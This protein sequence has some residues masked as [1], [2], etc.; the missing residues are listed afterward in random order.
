LKLKSQLQNELA[1][2][3]SREIMALMEDEKARELAQAMPERILNAEAQSRSAY[4]EREAWARAA[5]D[6]ALATMDIRYEAAMEA[7]SQGQLERLCNLEEECRCQRT[8][9]ADAEAQALQ[10]I[11]SATQDQA[12]GLIQA[13]A[14]ARAARRVGW[15]R[16]ARGWLKDATSARKAADDRC[17]AAMAAAYDAYRQAMAEAMI[18][19]AGQISDAGLIA[20]AR[21]TEIANGLSLN[22]LYIAQEL[23]DRL[24][25]CAQSGTEGIERLLAGLDNWRV[26]AA[27]DAT[28]SEL[29]RADEEAHRALILSYFQEMVSLRADGDERTHQAFAAYRREQE[30]HM[31]A[32]RRE[33]ATVREDE[34]RQLQAARSEGQ[35]RRGAAAASYL[36]DVA[37]AWEVRSTELSSVAEQE[38]QNRMVVEEQMQ[39]D[40]APHDAVSDL[41]AHGEAAMTEI[42]VK[43]ARLMEESAAAETAAKQAIEH[44]YRRALKEAQDLRQE[45]HQQALDIYRAEE[46]AAWI[47]HQTAM[48]AVK[49]EMEAAIGKD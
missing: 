8:G 33:L 28:P 30:A 2:E 24:G 14:D 45:A 26:S 6:E 43:Y 42:R 35:A 23:R 1:G 13:W 31:E 44:E 32:S 9:Y 25:G 40:P 18:F 19:E 22:L 12:H 11:L 47:D 34:N 5:R 49:A 29:I 17:D 41:L 37:R 3:E 4:A 38:S 27:E 21:A 48:E 10:N 16:R 20:E 15:K 36:K 39:G 46:R 7:A